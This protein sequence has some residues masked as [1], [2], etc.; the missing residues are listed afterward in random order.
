MS[1]FIRLQK[2]QVPPVKVDYVRIINIVKDPQ[3][4]LVR[5]VLNRL[6]VDGQNDVSLSQ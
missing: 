4:Y 2:E 3:T 1:A 5:E 6:I